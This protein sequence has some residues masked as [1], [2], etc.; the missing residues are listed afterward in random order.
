MRGRPNGHES[1]IS[2]TLKRNSDL[3][4]KFS[5]HLFASSL[6]EHFRVTYLDRQCLLECQERHH[7]RSDRILPLQQIQISI[8]YMKNSL[9]KRANIRHQRFR[10]CEAMLA[11]TQPPLLHQTTVLPVDGFATRSACC[12]AN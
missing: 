3:T 8:C 5:V 4:I 2:E 7:P 12:L 10:L 9:S 6:A 11:I 1:E